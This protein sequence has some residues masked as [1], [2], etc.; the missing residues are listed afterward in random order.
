MSSRWDLQF[1]SDSFRCSDL[2]DAEA[3]L[4]IA[5]DAFD[6]SKHSAHHMAW[7]SRKHV[8]FQDVINIS[9]IDQR[10]GKELGLLRN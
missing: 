1:T 7:H 5:V 6:G 10:V 8:P 4:A 3:R 9:G 2:F